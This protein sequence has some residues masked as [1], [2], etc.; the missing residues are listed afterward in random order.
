MIYVIVALLVAWI[1]LVVCDAP[2]R[3]S[4]RRRYRNTRT[5]ARLAREAVT[6]E[7]QR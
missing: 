3:L 7:P 4:I 2:V 6:E 5:A 1:L